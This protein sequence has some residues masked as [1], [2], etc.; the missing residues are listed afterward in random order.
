MGR[1]PKRR[2]V[3]AASGVTIG[4]IAGCTGR[5]QEGGQGQGQ[6]DCPD[7]YSLLAKLE[8]GGSGADCFSEVEEDESA[9]CIEIVGYTTKEDAA[10]NDCDEIVEVE[11]E[12]TGD[13]VVYQIRAFGGTDEEFAGIDGDGETSGTFTTNLM[14]NGGQRAGISNLHFCGVPDEGDEN[15]DGDNGDGDNGDGDN[16]DGDEDDGGDD[17]GKDGDGKSDK[18]PKKGEVNLDGVCYKANK[19]KAQFR[20]ENHGKEERTFTWKV[21]GTMQTGTVSVPKRDSE[22]I[23]V[24][25]D[26]DQKF[27]LYCNGDRVAKAKVNTMDC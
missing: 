9:S 26:T 23:W 10:D 5:A 14:T 6:Y 2:E 4:A 18:T 20:V 25:M 7:E 3:L 19:G 8:S 15:G 22:T 24:E 13:C 1:K 12:A 27:G 17:D 16:G 11:W 21:L